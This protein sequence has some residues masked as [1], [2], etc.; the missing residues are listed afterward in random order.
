MQPVAAAN[1]S[2]L[3]LDF[4]DITPGD[5]RRAEAIYSRWRPSRA[6]D[7]TPGVFA[8]WGPYFQ[9]K[10]CFDSNTLFMLGRAEDDPS[11][12][13]FT[14]PV[15]ALPLECALDRMRRYCAATGTPL[16]LTSVPAPDVER[17]RE[18]A[19]GC[20]VEQMPGWSDYLYDI[21]AL[22][23]LTGKKMNKKR[24]H[25]NRFDADNPGWRLDPLTEA[26][27]GDTLRFLNAMET[28]AAMNDM[29]LYERSRL[30]QE[31]RR[32]EQWATI[33]GGV[34]TTPRH[35]VVAFTLGETAGDTLV[36]HV[37]K[38]NHRVPGA[39]ETLAHAYAAMMLE[40]HPCLRFTNR[41]EDLG[42]PGLRHAKE[43]WHPVAMI[44]K[45]T[46]TMEA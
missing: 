12:P 44:D 46:V 42:D 25:V 17:L 18:A 15:G 9:R 37:E 45:Y 31:L 1:N 22:A 43:S 39:G 35:G 2:D 19:P 32:L 8:V 27:V 29:G 23:T 6:C 14:L 13:A 7:F 20:R 11:L 41:E 16:R 5:A 30:L 33:E 10:V 36:T 40:R 28:D 3:P 34:L 38:M 24:N 4:R 26:N 21:S